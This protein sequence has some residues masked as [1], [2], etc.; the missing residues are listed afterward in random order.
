MALT[1]YVVLLQDE[2]TD[3]QFDKVADNVQAHSSDH[4]IRV[5][6]EQAIAKKQLANGTVLVAVPARSWKPTP[7]TVATTTTIKLGGAPTAAKAPATV[8]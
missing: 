8:T 5:Y 4:A 3:G 6:A 2:T 7:I 1:A